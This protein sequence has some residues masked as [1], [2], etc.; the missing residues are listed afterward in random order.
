MTIYKKMGKHIS[1]IEVFTPIEKRPRIRLI[2]RIQVPPEC[3]GK[4]IGTHLL[5]SICAIADESGYTLYYRIPDIKT[6]HKTVRWLI[7][8]QFFMANNPDLMCRIPGPQD[9]IE[10]PSVE[11]IMGVRK[12]L[13][14][15]EVD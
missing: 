1:V 7:K 10:L 14:N 6:V 2:N 12:Y 4:G 5:S 15:G 11:D 3:R 13:E 8:Y 9:Q